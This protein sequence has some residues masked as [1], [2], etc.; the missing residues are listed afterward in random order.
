MVTILHSTVLGGSEQRRKRIHILIK[1]AQA[2]VLRMAF[3]SI[4]E[5]AGR[6]G[7]TL[8]G[9]VRNAGHHFRSFRIAKVAF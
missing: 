5:E 4:K 3:R 7:K 9:Q 2:V 1:V 8:L 6:L